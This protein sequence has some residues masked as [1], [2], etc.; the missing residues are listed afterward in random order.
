MSF[1]GLVGFEGKWFVLLCGISDF[2]I[3]PTLPQNA[4]KEPDPKF[5]F[6]ASNCV[7]SRRRGPD[8]KKLRDT[9][10]KQVT[11]HPGDVRNLGKVEGGS[12]RRFHVEAVVLIENRSTD[13][14]PV[15]P[16]PKIFLSQPILGNDVMH[17]QVG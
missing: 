9:C 6:K 14:V 13:A 11:R 2:T 7:S 10:T 4:C 1:V 3:F 16:L 5:V 8:G 17:D 12:L 15:K